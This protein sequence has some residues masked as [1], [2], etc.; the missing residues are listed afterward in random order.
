VRARLGRV[1]G[2]EPLAEPRLE[3]PGERDDALG[4]ARQELEVDVG[5]A[6]LVALEEPVAGQLDEVAKPGVVARQQRE[7]VA[8]VADGVGAAV[9][10]EVGLE[11]QDRLDPLLLARLVELDGAVHH[12]VVGQAQ[13]RLVELSR[14]GGERVDLARAVEQRVLAVD[15]QMCAGGRA[16][17]KSQ[18][19]FG[20]GRGRGAGRGSSR[21][22]RPS[23]ARSASRSSAPNTTR[24]RVAM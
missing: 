11:A 6:A 4:M 23:A 13:G 14:A 17:E 15:V 21:Y 20:S 7:V 10:H 2:H 1:V 24:F 19:R 22:L 3:A 9:V 5:L 8:L 16:H 12:A 18:N